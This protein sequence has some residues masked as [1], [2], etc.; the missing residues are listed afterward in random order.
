MAEFLRTRRQTRASILGQLL[1]S[2]GLFRPRLAAACNLTEASI[3]RIVAELRDEGIIEEVR[4]PSPYHGGPTQLVILR[5]DQRVAGLE[6][7]HGQVAFGVGALDGTLEAT[8]RYRLPRAMTPAALRATLTR[9][10]ERL[11]ALSATQGEAPRR[12]A[13]ALPGY[14]G[15]DGPA[16]PIL[17]LDA[18]WLA[19]RIKAVFPGVPIVMANSVAA[20]AALH[21]RGTP[22]AAPGARRLFLHLG[23]GVGGAWVDPIFA[24]VPIRPIEI[25][26]VVLQRGGPLCRCGHH[27]CLEAIA[28]T[29]AIAALLGMPESTLVEAGATWPDAVPMLARHEA[30]LRD[31]LFQLGLAIGNAL[32]LTQAGVVAIA[33][34]P[35][36]VPTPMHQAVVEGMEASLFGG[37][38]ANPVEL[39]FLP[40]AIGPAPQA[41]LAYAVHSLVRD[42]A[43][44]R[45][46][47]QALQNIIG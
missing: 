40:P 5:Q 14:R 7:A 44:P 42:G 16:N 39:R 46:P 38:A 6:V 1:A 8:A 32:N 31:V 33:G 35:A 18:G 22:D 30:A 27:G 9:A 23:H 12:L 3:S 20:H 21:L 4:R 43:M 41:A 47:D 11:A 37:L 25:G 24:A 17:P 36:R 15:V 34:W 19:R 29:T 10:V 28:S 13:V 26:H 45:L 2:G